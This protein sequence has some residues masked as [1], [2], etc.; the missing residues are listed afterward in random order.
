MIRLTTIV[1]TR[2]Q[3]IK[4]SAINRCIRDHFAE[5]IAETLLHT[6]QHY[7]LE[8]NEVFF[9]ELELPQPT[10]NLETGP[11]DKN[12]QISSMLQGVSHYLINEKPD[13]VLVYGDTN[14]TLAGALAASRL[15]IP[16]LHVEAGLRSN[17]KYMQEEMNRIL[18][19]RMSTLLFSPTPT[20]IHNLK[21]EG[22]NIQSVQPHNLN[23]PGI[24]HSGDVMLD[25]F[26][27]YSKKS[28]PPNKHNEFSNKNFALLTIH[29]AETT[30]HPERLKNVLSGIN[31][32]AEKQNLHVAFPLH[33]A[34]RQMMEHSG[35]SLNWLSEKIH[36]IAPSTYLETIWMLN[37]CQMVMTDS[38]G[39]QKEAAFAGKPCLVL[40]NRTEWKELE[41]NNLCVVAGVNTA[42][43]LSAAKRLSSPDS[44]L[45]E[46]LF[47]NGRA[48]Y[49]ICKII[50]TFGK[51]KDS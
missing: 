39:L 45:A 15:N 18:T 31:A 4:A 20:G 29:R 40:R 24:Y 38:G 30:H 41:K 17:N 44:K 27:Y 5:K 19:D 26:I 34:T 42:S 1:G 6:G 47:G 28:K 50:E 16:V 2:P 12:Q 11:A 14:S 37:H 33:P 23:N 43:I 10:Y 32:I 13:A 9:K 8:M 22:Y 46:N 21:A 51:V 25:N 48:A 35:I 36:P 49:N 3:F 7:D